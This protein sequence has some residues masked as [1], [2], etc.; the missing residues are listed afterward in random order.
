MVSENNALRV[1]PQAVN[2][3]ITEG[4]GSPVV[5]RLGF[6]QQ[7]ERIF[8]TLSED[9]NV[10]DSTHHFGFVVGRCAPGV[11]VQSFVGLLP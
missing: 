3:G 5:S 4:F 11:A 1:A 9:A 2:S 8:I 10:D 6:L 7:V